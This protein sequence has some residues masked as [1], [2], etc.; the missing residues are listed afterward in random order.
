MIVRWQDAY[1]ERCDIK[2]RSGQQTLLSV[3]LFNVSADPLMVELDV[4]FDGFGIEEE[5]EK[6]SCLM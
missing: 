3:I 1:S 4:T 5:K 2:G 6:P